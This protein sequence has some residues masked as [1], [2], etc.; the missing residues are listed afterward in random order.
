MESDFYGQD[1]KLDDQLQPVTSATGEPALTVGVET[2]I[3]QIRMALVTPIGSLFYDQDFGGYMHEFKRENND[4]T[5]QLSLVSELVRTVNKDENVRPN[6]TT[7]EILSMEGNGITAQVTFNLIN[8]DNPF[9]LVIE[10]NSDLSLLIKDI[11]VY[12]D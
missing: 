7:A 3:Q 5:E 11:N 8:E 9:N 4:E 1:I 12:T 6:E 10:K 2:A